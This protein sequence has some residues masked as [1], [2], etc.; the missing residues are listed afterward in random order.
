MKHFLFLALFCVLGLAC[1]KNQPSINPENPPP[2]EITHDVESL[3]IPKLIN[4]DYIDLSEVSQISK[5][6]SGIGHDYSDHFEKCRSMKHYYPVAK[7]TNIYAPVTGIVN[8]VLEEWAGYKIQIN[9]DENPAFYVEIFHLDPQ[10][11]IVVGDKL[12]AGQLLG[13][14]SSNSTMSDIAAFVRVPSADTV[15]T[16]FVSYFDLMTDELFENYQK[17]GVV[18]REDFIISKALRDS[19]PLDCSRDWGSG[20]G[21]LSNWADLN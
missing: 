14:H 12:T 5:F 20:M 10:T 1:K 2:G 15:A 17:R 6:R 13:Y 19:D 8:F 11:P 16:K 7:G 3:G 4:A 18:S 9:C 21:N